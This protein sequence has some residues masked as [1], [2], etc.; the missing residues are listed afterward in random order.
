MAF[1]LFTSVSSVTL[2]QIVDD[3][4]TYADLEP[5]LNVGGQTAT[6]VLSIAN[7]V[8]QA[9]FAE[10]F[11]YKWNEF[12]IP[13]I[14]SNSLQQDY[15]QVLPA[16]LSGNL[17][18]ISITFVS[19]QQGTA[20]YNGTITGGDFGGYVGVPFVITGFLTGANNGTF[21]C[22]ASSATALVLKNTGAVL[23]THAGNAISAAGPITNLAWLERGAAFDI[24][25]SSVPKPF[26]RIECGRQLPQLSA[27]YT[28]AAGLG[29]PGFRCNW[30][31]NRT[32]YYGTWG[33]A[34]V[35]STKI[36]NNPQAGSVYT[37]P[38]G[39]H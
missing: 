19:A 39:N 4:N 20:V 5:V 17:V 3:I 13:P 32:L 18:L 26:V 34:N 27:Q 15:A 24:N 6:K 33:A 23:E 22:V 28:G 14:F 25:N 9:I 36:G 11:P 35:G 29:D 12:N 1:G 16:G 38:T 31:P 8:M 7:T 10:P 30:F 2:Q 21:M 37:S